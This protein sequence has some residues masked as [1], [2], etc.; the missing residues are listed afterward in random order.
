MTL[1][2]LY[3]KWTS[4]EVIVVFDVYGISMCN[5]FSCRLLFQIHILINQTTGRLNY[6]ADLIGVRLASI[7]QILDP[8]VYILLR[9]SVIIKCFK[10]FKNFVTS[11]FSGHSKTIKQST[12]YIT[13]YNRNNNGYSAD[14]L[15]EVSPVCL[16]TGTTSVCLDGGGICENGSAK[17]ETEC[18]KRNGNSSAALSVYCQKAE[19]SDSSVNSGNNPNERTTL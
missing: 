8:W 9:K 6:R 19:D 12:K 4:A 14:C 18:L 16:E 2:V 13:N 10:T 15:S 3:L 1:N 7:N 5:H 17:P 11:E